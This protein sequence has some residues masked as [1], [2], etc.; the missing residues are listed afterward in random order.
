MT[1]N[2]VYPAMCQCVFGF[3]LSVIGF[4]EAHF[5]GLFAQVLTLFN[6]NYTRLFRATIRYIMRH[7]YSQSHSPRNK[8][9]TVLTVH[10]FSKLISC[11]T[12][13]YRARKYIYFA[14]AT[15]AT[16]PKQ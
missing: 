7:A 11:V 3:F 4:I 13:E 15:V 12:W 14:H 2:D 6:A 9:I 5:F 8:S 16:F 1:M 10:F